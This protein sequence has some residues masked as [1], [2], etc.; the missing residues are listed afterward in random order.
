MNEDLI[1]ASC[2]ISFLVV[3]FA[4]LYFSNEQLHNHRMECYKTIS[5]H[6]CVGECAERICK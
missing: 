2:V 6:G 1:I 4:G 3:I 5:E